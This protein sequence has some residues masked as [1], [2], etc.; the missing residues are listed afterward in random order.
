MIPKIIHYC[1]FGRN[2]K[3]ELIQKCIQSWKEKCP[4]YQIVEWNEDNWDIDAYPYAR[5]AYDAK[6]WAF[7][8][9][10]ARLDILYHHG[11]IYLDT[12]VELKESI[13]YWLKYDAFYAFE[14][15]LR[16]ATG[17]G[18]G[19]QKN[20]KSVKEMLRIYEDKHFVNEG[21]MNLSPC[22]IGNTKAF[23]T[24]YPGFIRNGK[25]QVIEDILILS[26]GDYFQYAKHHGAASWSE[27]PKKKKQPYKD[28]KLKRFLRTPEKFAFAEKH[29]GEK[30]NKVYIWFAYDFL[31]YGIWH[32]VKRI[33]WKI[34]E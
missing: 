20:H 30:G 24:T 14:S 19:A 6:K 27:G 31:E 26:C 5:E 29:F 1:W 10:V 3:S 33:C 7:V 15:E 11:G 16:I 13:D 21:K 2:P 12:D 22:P 23:I 34:M 4:D 17:L 28:T 32:Y 9:D 18:F 25:T 8:S